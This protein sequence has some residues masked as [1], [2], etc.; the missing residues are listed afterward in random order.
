MSWENIPWADVIFLAWWVAVQLITAG[1][2]ADAVIRLLD[3]WMA[4]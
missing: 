2:L 4:L 1:L 3:N